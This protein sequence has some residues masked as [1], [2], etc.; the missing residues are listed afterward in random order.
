MLT[1][2][3]KSGCEVSSNTVL[4]PM[5]QLTKNRASRMMVPSSHSRS[6]VEVPLGGEKNARI[7]AAARGIAPR[8][9]ASAAD[10]N[11][12]VTF[13]PTSYTDQTISPAHQA[14]AEAPS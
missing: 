13:M 14:A 10:G 5:V 9:P 2:L 11:G 12:T 8:K 1:L 6:L 3:P 7:P 4:R